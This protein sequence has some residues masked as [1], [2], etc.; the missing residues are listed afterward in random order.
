VVAGVA[1]DWPEALDPGAGAGDNA[2]LMPAVVT[3]AL[4]VTGVAPTKPDV[5]P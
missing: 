1:V 2:R 4:T 3:P 5:P